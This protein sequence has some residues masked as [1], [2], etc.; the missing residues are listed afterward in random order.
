MFPPLTSRRPNERSLR[1]L[2]RDAVDTAL[3]FATLGEA[4]VSRALPPEPASPGRATPLRPGSSAPTSEHPHR[5]PVGRIARARR[6]GGVAPRAQACVTPV[7]RGLLA[8]CG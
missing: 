7:H 1:V 4:T 2:V 3:E 8:T 6:P 5:R